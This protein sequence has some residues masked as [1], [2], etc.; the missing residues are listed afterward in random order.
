MFRDTSTQPSIP[1]R[2]YSNVASFTNVMLCSPISPMQRFGHLNPPAYL[3]ANGL[4]FP[5]IA[6]KDMGQATPL[7]G[8]SSPGNIRRRP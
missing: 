7:L 3:G 1:D 5:L 8:T 4:K 2:M 6:D